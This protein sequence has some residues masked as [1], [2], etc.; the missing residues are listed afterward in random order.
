MKLNFSKFTKSEEA[1][2]SH[3]GVSLTN[4]LVTAVFVVLAVGFSLLA[5]P[6]ALAQGETLTAPTPSASTPVISPIES[7]T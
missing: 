7:V 2:S 3:G 1:P 6:N 5:Q 4:W